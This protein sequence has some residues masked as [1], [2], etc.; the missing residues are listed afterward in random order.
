[1]MAPFCSSE[2]TFTLIPGFTFRRCTF[3]PRKLKKLYHRAKLV[4]QK[5][6]TES[7]YSRGRLSASV[8]KILAECSWDTKA[9]LQS[10]QCV[11]SS[12]LMKRCFRGEHTSEYQIY[13][14]DTH[15]DNRTCCRKIRRASGMLKSP[16]SELL[17]QELPA[18]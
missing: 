8:G 7:S 11:G 17:S 16:R 4:L 6:R 2:F 3:L 13:T 12:Q 9:H 1:M 15:A 5:K 14:F 10:H 18:A